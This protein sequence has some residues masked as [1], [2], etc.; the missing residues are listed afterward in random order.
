MTRAD[1]VN[2]QPVP[3]Y[4][5]DRTSIQQLVRDDLVT[6]EQLGIERYGTSL[7]ANNGRDSVVDAYQEALDLACYLRQTI[8]RGGLVG[9]DGAD[10]TPRDGPVRISPGQLLASILDSSGDKR[11][12]ICQRLLSSSETAYTCLSGDHIDQI[13]TLKR[14]NAMLAR[15]LLTVVAGKPLSTNSDAYQLAQHTA[16]VAN[17]S[18]P[19]HG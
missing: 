14:K 4:Q 6:R 12:E 8:E 3:I 5:A 13:E 1:I 16:S 15:T 7:Q 19:S 10:D 11:L 18:E 2:E 9:R 17:E